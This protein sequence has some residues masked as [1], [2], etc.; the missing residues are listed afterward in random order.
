VRPRG[1]VLPP[2]ASVEDIGAGIELKL[3]P[4]GTEQVFGR[5][6]GSVRINPT[7]LCRGVGVLLEDDRKQ[8]LG[9]LSLFVEDA[10]YV[11]L[12]RGTPAEL[13]SLRATLSFADV[14]PELHA[15]EGGHA[16]VVGPLDLRAAEALRVA[17]LERGR[18]AT[19]VD[20]RGLVERIGPLD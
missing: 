10:Q 9:S 8:H 1:R 6:R 16:L 15:V 18:A 5:Y 17:L 4:R 20:G 12:G 7:T 13:R 11:E 14:T 19:L 3:R 2:V